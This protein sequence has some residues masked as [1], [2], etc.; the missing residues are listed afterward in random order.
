MKKYLIVMVAICCA[1]PQLMAQQLLTA[2]RGSQ[3]NSVTQRIGL[4]DITIEYSSPRVNDREIWGAV[5]PYGETP[6][7]WRA[8]ANENTVITLSADAQVEGKDLEAGSYGLHIVPAESGDWTLIFSNDY[9]AWGSFNYNKDNDALRVSVTPE[10][11][12]EKREWLVFEFADKGPDYAVASLVWDQMRIPFRIE[13]DLHGQV[14]AS[15]KAELMSLPGFSWQGPMQA[16]NYC[17]T[18]DVEL[19]QGMA[20]ADQAINNQKNF[21]TMNTKAGLLA[22]MGKQA[23]ADE[24]MV[25]AVD[26]PSTTVGDLYGYGRQLIG[27][28]KKDEAMAIFKKNAKRNPDHWLAPHGMARAYSAKG[29]FKK[30]LP[31]EREALEKA[32]AGSKGFLEGFVAQ[33]EK[34]ED[35]N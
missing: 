24:L 27:Q 9:Q 10:T 30:A 21:N 1:L 15:Y 7:P 29:D 26:L 20:W 22:K 13:V 8:G 17:L 11:L 4:T 18:N 5:V 12:Q 34:G 25:E 32:P 6:F 23:E 28:G 3:Y 35:F 19:E 14:L 33:L 2:P 31:L 16:A